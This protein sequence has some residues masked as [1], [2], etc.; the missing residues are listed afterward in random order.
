MKREVGPAV[1][2]SAVK[3]STSHGQDHADQAWHDVELR[4]RRWIVPGVG[5][6]LKRRSA[7][8]RQSVF[9]RERCLNEW[10]NC[11]APAATGSVALAASRSRA[12]VPPLPTPLRIRPTAL[13]VPA[14]RGAL[15]D[16]DRPAN[17]VGRTI[18]VRKNFCSSGRSSSRNDIS[19]GPSLSA[20]ASGGLVCLTMQEIPDRI[21][22]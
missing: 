21:V 14:N 18:H 22:H 2:E 15:P 11:A 5:A 19:S 17:S 12:R 16:L 20:I 13:P 6:H 1:T 10:T 4:I 9:V 8:V 7:D 3:I